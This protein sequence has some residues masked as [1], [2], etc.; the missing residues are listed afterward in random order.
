M[1]AGA[2]AKPLQQLT[3]PIP[4]A[5]FRPPQ[6]SKDDR[7]VQGKRERR[8]SCS[9]GGVKPSLQDLGEEKGEKD[10][11]PEEE[12]GQWNALVSVPGRSRECWARG[13]GGGSRGNGGG[14][15]SIKGNR[16]GSR[17]G[18]GVAGTPTTPATKGPQVTKPTDDRKGKGICQVGGQEGG[19]EEGQVRG[20]PAASLP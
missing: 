9:G 11:A 4:S 6:R 15:G 18:A 17:H 19:D 2:G 12:A 16:P 7:R 1:G 20:V 10:V 13:S 3:Q 5:S 8:C 14:G